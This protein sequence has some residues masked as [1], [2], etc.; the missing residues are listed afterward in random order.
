MLR[1]MSDSERKAERITPRA[2]D[3]PQWYQDVIREAD[4]AEPA[5]V[6]KGCMVI[7]PYGYAIWEKIQRSL[8]AAFKDTGHQNAYFPLLVPQSFITKEA[9]HVEGFAPELAVVT[10]AGGEQLE[11]PYVIRPTSETIIG[12]FFSKWISSHRDLPL[13]VNQWANVMRW[14]LRTRLF[15]RTTEFL[16]QEGHTA[17]ATHE[18]AERE[19]RRMLDVYGD[20]A[21]QTMAM[22]VVRGVKTESEKFAGAVQSLCIEAMMQDGKA[23]QAGTSHDLGQ[24]FGKAFDVKFQTESGELE[25]VWQTSW[26]VSTRLIGGLIMTHS[27]DEGLVLPPRLAP[28]HAV[29]VPIYR[30]DADRARVMEAAERL[31]RTL[32]DID[33]SSERARWR[34]FVEVHVDD[35]DLRP[36]AKYYHWERRGVPVRIEL[37]PKDLDKG[38]VCVKMRTDTEAGRGKEFID[39]AEFVQTLRARLERYQDALLARARQRLAEQA[40]T[41]DRWEDFLETFAGDKSTFAWCHW[42][43]TKETEAEIKAETKVTIRCIPLP[44]QGP[45]PEPGKCIKSGKPSAQRVLMAKA[46]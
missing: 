30:S 13:L 46:Y 44:G 35:R 42:D 6:V 3:Y 28:I 45:A 19:V 21:E 18:E 20:F 40:V 1:A 33:L 8:D 17:H 24:N 5:K 32:A 7:K 10:H 37:G 41:L 39:E 31:R 22:P 38:Q 4:L 2:E 14:E 26:G 16:W 12:H 15:L 23:L 34:D 11:E 43:G 29:I 9:E 25:Y 27:D 36:G